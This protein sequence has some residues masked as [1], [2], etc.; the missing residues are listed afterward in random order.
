MAKGLFSLGGSFKPMYVAGVKGSRFIEPHDCE[1]I[2][3]YRIKYDNAKQ[4]AK[5]I[6]TVPDG[7]RA[8]VILNGNFIFGDLI[9][10]MVVNNNWLCEEITISTLSMSQDNIDSLK[11]L[12]K[13]GYVNNL[14]LIVSHYYFATER[15]SLMPYMY[16]TLD[17]DDKFQVAVAS[18]HTKICMIRTS[19][20]KKIVIHG[21]ANMRSSSNIEQIVI[22]N[23]PELFDFSAEIHHAIIERHKTINKPVRRNE[24]W[25]AVLAVQDEQKALQT[26]DKTRRQLKEEI[27]NAQLKA[28]M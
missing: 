13:G 1:E 8:F 25:R 4:L 6:G 19:C 22:E 14:N 5:D 12:L 20:G 3:D 17:V 10:A 26:G 11:N 9:E 24:L 27:R 28:G 15:N 7:F 18:V 16:E 23:S 2:A 21:S